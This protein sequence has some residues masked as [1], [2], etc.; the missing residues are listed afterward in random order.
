MSVL[1]NIQDIHWRE[2]LWLLLSLQPIAIYYIKKLV[3]NNKLVSYADKHLHPWLIFTSDLKI[4]L[5]S[6]SNFIFS[7]NTAYLL[8][9]FLLAVALAG[10]RTH[11]Q[12]TDVSQN[13]SRNI[14]LVVDLSRSMR[15]TDI[16]PNRLQRAQI[17]INEFLS[18]VKGHR[19][20]VIVYSARPHIF[21]P[22]TY[23]TKVLKKYIS[24]ID[25]L[26][27][28]TYGSNLESAINLAATELNKVMGKSSVL[29]IS[30]GD[31]KEKPTTLN[32]KTGGQ[33]R[34]NNIPLFILGIGTSEG[35]AILLENGSWLTH[36]QQPVISRT[37]EDYLKDLASHHSGKYSPVYD[38][39][40]DWKRLYSNGINEIGHQIN[41]DKT[42]TI[43]WDEHFQIF[44]ITA[45]F[46][47][48]IALTPFNLTFANPVLLVIMTLLI[49][50]TF[51][52]EKEVLAFDIKSS[53]E[54]AFTA[55][56]NGEYLKAEKYYKSMSGYSS[57]IG[58]GNSL[59]KLG[60]FHKA[61]SHFTQAILSAKTDKQRAIALYN[62]ANSHFRT[63]D[64]ST[65]IDT[66]T[67]SLIYSPNN[68]MSL[69]NLNISSELKKNIELRI[70]NEQELFTSSRQGKGPRSENIA[71]AIDIDENTSVSVG[72]SSNTLNKN[73]SLPNL[74]S[75]DQDTIEKLLLT[76]LEA[77]KLANNSTAKIIS[78]SNT[79]TSENTLTTIT[80]LREIQD[81]Q[82]L[83]W[84]RIFEMEEGFPA[85]VDEA[86]DIPGINPW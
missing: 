47:F 77:V 12:N 58:I 8:G 22:L 16:E 5:H 40:S 65:A 19:I 7:K 10:P 24:M 18:K 74:P 3:I 41:D 68:K 72:E 14:M 4:S 13:M 45:I 86:H 44:L 52:P 73:I 80:Q 76:G 42:T 67:D 46:F 51:Y 30:D 23:D 34:E 83:L 11:S 69:Y 35:E 63:G 21:V 85:P 37:N 48:L 75:L 31:N 32:Q 78:Q 66:Y 62:L 9:W 79:S 64:F 17:E 50:L 25:K 28:P 61:K 59:Y 82:H 2:P 57:Q 29:L 20:G 6:F 43:I 71:N 60:H 55:Y 15:A 56:K 39:D 27:F 81:T 84:K 70:K 36:N 53:S 54:A 33:L 26:S 38:D 49:A 1:F